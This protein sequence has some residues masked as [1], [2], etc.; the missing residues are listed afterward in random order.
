MVRTAKT[1]AASLARN[2]VTPDDIKE[3]AVPVLS[4]RILLDAEAQF[5]GTTIYEVIDAIL[6]TVVPPTERAA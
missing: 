3:L 2:F 5:S 6:A 4:H 1:W